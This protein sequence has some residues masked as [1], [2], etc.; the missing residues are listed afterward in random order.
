MYFPREEAGS[1]RVGLTLVS[2]RTENI[3][4]GLFSFTAMLTYCPDQLFGSTN[5]ISVEQE[6]RDFKIISFS[7]LRKE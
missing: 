6:T 5:Y 1:E 2:H 3:T 7:T 4:D